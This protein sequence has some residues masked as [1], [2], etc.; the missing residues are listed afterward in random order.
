MPYFIWLHNIFTTDAPMD[1]SYTLQLLPIPTSRMLHHIL[2]I[3]RVICLKCWKSCSAPGLKINASTSIL[4]LR[5]ILC[6]KRFC[7]YDVENLMPCRHRQNLIFI[8]HVLHLNY[9]GH[10]FYFMCCCDA[11]NR[12]QKL[13]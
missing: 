3:L 13:Y 9:N 2:H 11:K 1:I 6:D 8:I 12:H 7:L 5:D 10:S 4:I